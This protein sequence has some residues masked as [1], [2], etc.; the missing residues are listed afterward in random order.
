MV[1][2]NVGSNW[3]GLMTDLK[4]QLSLKFITINRAVIK[5]WWT[6]NLDVHTRNNVI[7]YFMGEF[8]QLQANSPIKE[9][10]PLQLLNGLQLL[11]DSPDIYM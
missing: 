1:E 6:C 2:Q 8:Y 11:I 9:T 10:Q 3:P 7:N 4:L 5:F